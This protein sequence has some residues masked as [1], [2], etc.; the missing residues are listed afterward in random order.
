MRQ[1]GYRSPRGTY[2][3]RAPVSQYSQRNLAAS[4]FVV[5]K[6]AETQTTPE[7]LQDLV[8]GN[9]SYQINRAMG[10]EIAKTVVVLEDY[11]KV[12]ASKQKHD[13]KIEL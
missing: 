4:V 12:L 3:P 13:A 10:D 11:I 2:S 8:S 7:M 5:R 1:P 9:G 6:A